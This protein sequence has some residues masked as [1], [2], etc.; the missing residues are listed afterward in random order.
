MKDDDLI[1]QVLEFARDRTFFSYQELIDH[2][3]IE[4]SSTHSTYLRTLID[5]KQV[6]RASTYDYSQTGLK[7]KRLSMTVE[8]RFKLLSY[9]ELKEDRQS[10]KDAKRQAVFALWVSI[11]AIVV[12]VIFDIIS[13]F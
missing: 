7:L 12:S 8:D 6:L 10:S 13:L 3:G 1:I 5:L 2:L 9:T 11:S 4:L